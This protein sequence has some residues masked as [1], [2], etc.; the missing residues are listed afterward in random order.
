[1]FVFG[2][3]WVLEGEEKAKKVKEASML[4]WEDLVRK[5]LILPYYP[6]PH[7]LPMCHSSLCQHPVPCSCNILSTWDSH[8]WD[9]I[10]I[11][12]TQTKIRTL[13]GGLLQ[14]CEWW[15]NMREMINMEEEWRWVICFELRAYLRSGRRCAH[16][17]DC[18]KFT[19]IGGV[20]LPEVQGVGEVP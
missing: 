10:C 7:L 16:V 12:T 1:M 4:G 13:F 11:N 18:Q 14:V 15:I 5:Y 8:A 20:R 9:F 19:S 2:S 6:S 17:H 3:L